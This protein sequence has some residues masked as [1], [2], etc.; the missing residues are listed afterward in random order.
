MDHFETARNIEEEIQ[1]DAAALQAVEEVTGEE[2]A[3]AEKAP[4]AFSPD[5][6][7]G[8]YLRETGRYALLTPQ[9][10][11]DLARRIVLGDKKARE[12]MIQANLR[13]VVSLAKRYL[14][15][16]LPFSDLIQEGNIGLMKAVA[17]FD[18]ELGYK[19]STYATWWIRQSITRAIADQALLIRLPVHMTESVNK[20][21]RTARSLTMDLGREPSPEEIAVALGWET[22][23]VEGI[24]Q[25]N[26][27]TLSLD[28]PVGEDGEAHIG[29]FIPDAG[30]E[31][32]ES[33]AEDAALC[34]DLRKALSGLTER[35]R[36][37][38]VLRFGLEDGRQ[39]TLEE[40]GEEFH[41]TRERIRQIES[42]ALRKLRHP[43]RAKLLREYYRF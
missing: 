38:I 9:Q 39:R 18:P 4:E 11:A 37:V 8:I 13:L 5:D 26:T 16:G 23:R 32:P 2:L 31:S 29:E 41:V 14:N 40:V 24:L 3:Q 15:R 20:V 10:E 28:T 34:H 30:A 12:A 25:L 17:K 43:R 19:F 36:K 27:D 21:R 42:K 35:E 1:P 22:G 6:S 33:A 7:L